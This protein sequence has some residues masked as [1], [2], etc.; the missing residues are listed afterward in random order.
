MLVLQ[1]IVA[2]LAQGCVYGLIAGGFVL[3]YKATETVNFAQGDPMLLGAFAGLALLA[4]RAGGRRGD[5][6]DRHGD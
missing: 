1:I 2:G 3:I 4:G 5:G 6:A